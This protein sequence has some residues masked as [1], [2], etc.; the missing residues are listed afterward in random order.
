M[1]D[2]VDIWTNPVRVE[3]NNFVY[4]SLSSWSCNFAVGCLHACRFCYVPDVSTIK[5]GSKLAKY[6]VSNPDSEWGD[7]LMV[8]PFDEGAMRA[9]VRK[10]EQTPLSDLNIDG[11]RAVMFSTTTD[12]YQ[13]VKHP[14]A[15]RRAFLQGVLD[16]SV[17]RT[18]EIIRDESTLNVRILTR[19][20]LAKQSFELFKTFGDR[21]LFGMSLPTVDNDLARIYEPKA[22]APSQRLAT[23]RAARDA[24]VHVF[25]AVAPTYP[26]MTDDDLY[27]V[28]HEVSKLDPLTVFHEP[29]NIRAENVERISKHA[30]SLGFK[31]RRET[32]MAKEMWVRYSM[33]QM[34]KVEVIAGLTGLMERL[35]LWPDKE[36]GT[37][38][39]A[40]MPWFKKYWN[41]VS[42]WPGV[43]RVAP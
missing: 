37:L 8:R 27:E 22:P 1:S 7:Y 4:K 30:E 26:E 21:L 6:G 15:A 29:I 20:P 43:K 10:A 9:S 36:L 24:G 25:V 23:L 42:E 41:R 2:T 38:R 28:M 11:N 17:R 13:V 32:W 5:L 12:A 40:M 19:S 18:L 35:H 16:G 3:R 33:S 34:Q 39:P 14:D 31:I